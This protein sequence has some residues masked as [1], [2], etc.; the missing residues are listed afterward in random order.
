[1]VL[2]KLKK[3]RNKVLRR[4]VYSRTADPAT[5]AV[6]EILERTT[7]GPVQGG[8]RNTF[9]VPNAKTLPKTMVN[10][11]LDR[12][13]KGSVKG[14]L[15]A[16]AVEAEAAAAA[17]K[18]AFTEA[19]AVLNKKKGNAAAAAAA[20]ANRRAQLRVLKTP[21]YRAS[22]KT[23]VVRLSRGDRDTIWARFEWA[24]AVA[25][26]VLENVKRGSLLVD[27]EYRLPV[28]AFLKSAHEFR[29]IVRD[30]AKTWRNSSVWKGK[31]DT[32]IL[33]MDPVMP[34]EDVDV[35][36]VKKLR[37]RAA[38]INKNRMQSPLSRNANEYLDEFGTVF[39]DFLRIVKKRKVFSI[40]GVPYSPKLS[41]I[42]LKD[43][44]AFQ[45][46]VLINF[47]RN[48][49]K[50]GFSLSKMIYPLNAPKT[51]QKENFQKV[52]KLVDWVL[53]NISPDDEEYAHKILQMLGLVRGVREQVLMEAKSPVTKKLELLARTQ[54][55]E[56]RLVAAAKQLRSLHSLVN[57]IDLLR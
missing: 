38:T 17:V 13:T 22:T 56:K 12:K 6:N 10:A 41:K 44:A 15:R 42:V 52:E 29:K 5:Y 46:R 4:G 2:K 55:L 34:F 18:A 40:S 51:P 23:N 9:G 16:A 32:S 1:M 21:R 39:G 3:V 26:T 33:P 31:S 49:H 57:V 50:H 54:E 48:Y 19:V 7:K 8:L 14:G 24:K 35:R 47:V 53:T 27:K 37:L 45:K 11:I 36:T 20:V 30:Q 43:T 25:D 28:E